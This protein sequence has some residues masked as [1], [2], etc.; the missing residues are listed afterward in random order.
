[1]KMRVIQTFWML[2]AIS[3][4][5][6]FQYPKSEDGT[7]DQMMY[8][9]GL[10]FKGPSMNFFNSLKP[11]DD[12]QKCKELSTKIEAIEDTAS[13]NTEK[14]NSNCMALKSIMDE[15]PLG[16]Q[17]ID[18]SVTSVADLRT[19]LQTIITTI[20]TKIDAITDGLITCQKESI[21]M[22]MEPKDNTQLCKELLTKIEAIEDA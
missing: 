21:G 19:S 8:D 5:P 4:K 20:T 17:T 14:I 22:P 3:C 16:T 15:T 13:S 9:V 1:M 18:T 2:L 6:S 12:S 10:N 7:D 11:K